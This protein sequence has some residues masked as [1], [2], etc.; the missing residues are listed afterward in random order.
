M[1]MIG[2]LNITSEPRDDIKRS[3]AFA[4]KNCCLVGRSAVGE[5]LFGNCRD[6]RF[7][8]LIRC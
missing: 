1:R 3:D 2:H 6:R 4:A 7:K 8:R 5:S